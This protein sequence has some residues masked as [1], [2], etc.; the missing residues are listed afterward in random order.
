[1]IRNGLTDDN[2]LVDNLRILEDDVGALRAISGLSIHQ[3]IIAIT[4]CLKSLQCVIGQIR[5][6]PE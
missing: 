6:L 4:A 1:M 5:C 3:V 2:K